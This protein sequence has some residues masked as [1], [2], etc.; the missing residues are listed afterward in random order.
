MDTGKSFQVEG[1]D[2]FEIQVFWNFGEGQTRGKRRSNEIRWL[3]L[4]QVSTI[5][6]L[7]Q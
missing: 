6:G 7:L 1:G 3:L 2:V 4:F 5:D